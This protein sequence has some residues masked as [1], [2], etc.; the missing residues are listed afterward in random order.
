MAIFLFLLVLHCTAL[1]ALF[2]VALYIKCSSVF[3]CTDIQ[4]FSCYPNNNIWKILILHFQF[5]NSLHFSPSFFSCCTPQDF[6]NCIWDHSHTCIS[7]NGTLNFPYLYGLSVAGWSPGAVPR[8][9]GSFISVQSI[10]VTKL[11]FL[12]WLTNELYQFRAL[13]FCTNHT[14][15]GAH[16]SVQSIPV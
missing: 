11:F 1:R 15:L 12:Y 7:G 13:F 6:R 8:N 10:P 2:D 3:L 4:I 14:S 9:V 5:H 16:F